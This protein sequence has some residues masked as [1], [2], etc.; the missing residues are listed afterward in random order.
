MEKRIDLHLSDID[1]YMETYSKDNIFYMDSPNTVKSYEK[2]TNFDV[3]KENDRIYD[4]HK[5]RQTTI[6]YKRYGQFISLADDVEP[7]KKQIVDLFDLYT[8]LNLQKTNNKKV[9]F[10]KKLKMLF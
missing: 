6:E 1:S 3:S 8:A 7:E 2:K 4:A 5:G 9:S 10:F